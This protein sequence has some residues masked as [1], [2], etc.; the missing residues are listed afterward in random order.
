MLR[1]QWRRLNKRILA[2]AAAIALAVSAPAAWSASVDFDI[3]LEIVS[4]LTLTKT[5]DMS[6][7]TIQSGSIA[8]VV[9]LDAATGVCGSIS[10]DAITGACAPATI[11]IVGPAVLVTITHT[12]LTNMAGVAGLNMSF[13]DDR[14][15]SFTLTNGVP[16]PVRIGGL[17]TVPAGTD[18]PPTTI[19]H[20]VD[21]TF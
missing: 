12:G 10:G 19:T 4:P 13:V 18:L 5:A 3:L 6:F 8:S 2:S 1:I 9:A 14:G 11:E 21:V 15:G 16:N 20:S 17:L 7:G